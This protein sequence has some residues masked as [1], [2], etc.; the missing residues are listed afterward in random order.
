MIRR[1]PLIRISLG[2][3]LVTVSV[4]ITGDLLFQLGDTRSTA[5]LEARKLL[6]ES[7]AIQLATLIENNDVQ[8]AERT[9][10]SAVRRAPDVLS[11]AIRSAN[12]D[13]LLEVGVHSRYW[14]D[15]DSDKSTPTHTQVPIF[16]GDEQF[17]T[18]QLRFAPMARGGFREFLSSP[19]GRL[20]LFVAAMGF[21]G[22]I[23][24]M[25][26]TLKHLDPSAV[27]PGRVKTALDVLAE[28][29][30]LIDEN[31]DIVL[32]NKAFANELCEDASGLL[33]ISLSKMNWKLPEHDKHQFPWEGAIRNGESKLG[34]ALQLPTPAHEVRSFVVNSSPILDE[35]NRSRGAMVTFNDVTDL[36]QANA[37][38]RQTIGELESSR[39][40][41]HRQNQ[42]LNVLATQDPL[43]GCLNRRSFFD[44]GQREFT[45]A[46]RDEQPISCIMLD[47]DHFKSINDTYGHAAGDQVIKKLAD[48]VRASLRTVDIVGRYGGEE[49]CILLTGLSIERAADVAERLRQ[50]IEAQLKSA[51]DANTDRV[52]T[53]S[54]GVVSSHS[55]AENV[56]DL[57]DQADQALYSSKNNGR[58]RVTRWNELKQQV[59]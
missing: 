38:L 56:H 18:V 42:A 19:F 51:L 31:G 4:L 12:G 35:R 25:K 16:K 32:A 50:Q 37:E 20:L 55:G 58:N 8:G 44:H 17:A 3:V 5:V 28:G 48:I 46:R 59:A 27:I 49:F 47:I 34:A 54:I 24:F 29:V 21:V 15:I 43:S 2:L 52:V 22:Y 57:V 53:S 39:N 23:I 26:R 10:K 30:V 6:S 40:E 36:E 33:G 1:S 11:A 13:L 45:E 41:I 7:L 14:E 9:L